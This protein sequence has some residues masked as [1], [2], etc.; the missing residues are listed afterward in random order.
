MKKSLLTLLVALVAVLSASAQ[1]TFEWG[2]ATWNIENGKSYADIQQYKDT[3]VTLTYPNPNNYTLTMFNVVAVDYDVFVDNSTEA[4]AASSTAQGNT[5]VEISYAFVE[6]H[7]YKLNVKKAYLVQINI[8]TRTTDTLS[9][10]NDAYSISFS[11][12]GPELVKT[13]E[14]EGTMSLAII[15]QNYQPTFSVVDAAAI[16]S[17]LGVNNI[18]EATA[19]GLNPDGSY[20]EFFMSAYDGWRDVEAQYT[21]YQAGWDATAK[22]NATPAV[23]SIKLNETA[24]T[25][26]YYFYDTWKEYDPNAPTE[27]GGSTV[28]ARPRLASTSYNKVVWDWD[29]GDGT[30]TK[31]T[32]TYRVDEGVDYK[33]SFLLIAN[34]KAVRI[35]STLHFV[36]QESYIALNTKKYEGYL[37]SGIAMAAQPGTS[38][39]DL[40]EAETVSIAPTATYD[41]VNIT[42]SSI[43][44]PMLNVSAGSQTILAVMTENEDGSISYSA[45]DV[46]VAVNLNGM[47][48]PYKATLT[49]TQTSADAFPTFVLSLAQAN[50][51]S[52]I[53]AQTKEEAETARAAYYSGITGIF[54]P[55][56]VKNSSDIY[57]INGV[58][59]SSVSKGVNIINAK[60]VLVK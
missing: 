37:A 23:Y 55:S 27:T 58:R 30:T 50:V 51:V 20:N 10:N 9:V 7:S 13:I 36:S 56:S 54:A 25:V 38:L 6:G 46:T 60:K 42:F 11:I 34:K 16:C 1:T 32:R 29:N 22:R 43:T 52:V 57:N 41:K 39:A 31:Y 21:K 26:R 15:D 44:I 59:Q 19:Y 49:G 48:L 24:D 3:P 18:S 28:G 47:S 53:F 8:A 45:Q 5:A 17:A 35:N 4:I 2:T 12:A 33:A 14:T 40:S